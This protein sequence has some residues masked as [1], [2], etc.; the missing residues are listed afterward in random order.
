MWEKILYQI[1]G[2]KLGVRLIRKCDLYAEFYGTR[3]VQNCFANLRHTLWETGCV[4]FEYA[5]NSLMLSAASMA[6]AFDTPPKQNN[7]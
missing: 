5:L 1:L 6:P 2:V 4:G 7:K 3:S